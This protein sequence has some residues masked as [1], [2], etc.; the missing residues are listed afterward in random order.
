MNLRQQFASLKLDKRDYWSLTG[1]SMHLNL[2]LRDDRDQ[3]A[4]C[5]DD[6][7]HRKVDEFFSDFPIHECLPEASK[8][9]MLDNRLAITVAA[10][11]LEQYRRPFGC[12]LNHEVPALTNIFDGYE[13]ISFIIHVFKYY[14]DSG[15]VEQLHDSL[16]QSVQSAGTPA[17][18]LASALADMQNDCIG[19]EI[20]QALSQLPPYFALRDLETPTPIEGVSYAEYLASVSSSPI[21]KSTAFTSESPDEGDLL[22]AD[23]ADSESL[24]KRIELLFPP[25]W[26]YTLEKWHKLNGKEAPFPHISMRYSL[27]DAI[28]L[29]LETQEP[30]VIAWDDCRGTPFSFL[31]LTSALSHFVQ[32]FC[33]NPPILSKLAL[34]E[35][36]LGIGPDS[37]IVVPES[38]PFSYAL[39]LLRNRK[40]SAVPL[41]K[42]SGSF[43]GLLSVSQICFLF[44]G[45]MEG[46]Q[47]KWSWTDSV[48][49]VWEGLVAASATHPSCATHTYSYSSP[50]PSPPASHQP[51]QIQSSTHTQSKFGR[52]SEPSSSTEASSSYPGRSHITS[53]LGG[54]FLA[55]L[56]DYASGGI[57]TT[58]TPTSQTGGATTTTAS[59]TPTS[60]DL[61]SSL[62][63]KASNQEA[64]SPRMSSTAPGSST[65]DDTSNAATAV[66]ALI[67]NITCSAAVTDDDLTLKQVITHIVLTDDRRVIFLDPE[68]HR[69][70]GYITPSRLLRFLLNM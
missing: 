13:V 40:W 41:V 20:D 32:N 15:Y 12:V 67:K 45:S 48:R 14:T 18:D 66:Q 29:L 7:F 47:P 57:S 31:S 28:Q 60:H 19:R 39:Q 26:E 42:E 36:G 16:L 30:R 55:K 43:L 54:A 21:A 51:S 25:P 35:L 33:G 2:L 44:L 37:L 68:T 46:R 53:K 56:G 65:T 61:P 11:A 6:E 10:R 64:R 8:L 59:T 70:R 52:I 22:A 62:L 3:P 5:H 69:I 63:P 24:R 9:L 58:P 38:A 23:R 34:S 49:S 50:S 4:L 1:M 27:K 17:T